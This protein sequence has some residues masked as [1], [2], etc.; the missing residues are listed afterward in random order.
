VAEAN[1]AKTAFTRQD[2][3]YG[4]AVSAYGSALE[5]LARAYEADPD[6]ARDLLQDIHLSLWRSF[7]AFEGR[8]SLRTWMYR[9]A[10]NT[11]TS[12]VIQQQRRNAPLLDLEDIEAIAAH[13]DHGDEVERQSV[14]ERL[15]DL[16]HRLKPMD[17]QIILLYLEDMDAATIGEITGISPGNVRIQVHRI[18][19]ILIRRFHQRGKL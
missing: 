16:I 15:F 12:Y 13:H 19:N 6:K 4:E 14:L 7:E 18:R 2:E 11:A 1:G 5:R 8:C 9:V 17:R 10:H 3:L